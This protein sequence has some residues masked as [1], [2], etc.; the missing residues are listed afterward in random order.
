MNTSFFF[1]THLVSSACRVLQRLCQI[2]QPT[3]E[4]NRTMARGQE[5]SYLSG[6]VGD[7]R[8]YGSQE[9]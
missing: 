4:A 8:I 6:S 5:T 7:G 9:M 3:D 2:L 1:P